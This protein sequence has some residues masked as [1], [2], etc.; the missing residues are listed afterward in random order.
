MQLI[1]FIQICLS[2]LLHKDSDPVVCFC[3]CTC[4]LPVKRLFGKM[5]KTNLIIDFYTALPIRDEQM[6]GAGGGD[7]LINQSSTPKCG[8]C[9]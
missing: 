6:I 4:E 7:K 5:V 9:F 1:L 8:Y 2:G 3:A